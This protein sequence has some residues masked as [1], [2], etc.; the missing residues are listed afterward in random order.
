M[1]IL[2]GICHEG[3]GVSR[4]INVFFF[5]RGLK[6]DNFDRFIKVRINCK[7]KKWGNGWKLVPLREG[8]S[9]A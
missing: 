4:A 5:K 7:Q 2:S 3:G 6:N 8:W 1:D 9:D